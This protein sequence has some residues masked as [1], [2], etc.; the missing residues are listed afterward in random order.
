MIAKI[1]RIVVRRY[2]D[3][4]YSKLEI[5]WIDARGKRGL[6]EGEPDLRNAHMA[7]LVARGVREGV[8]VEQ[9]RS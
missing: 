4:G 2:G 6:T 9:V 8:R 3:S 7:A 1:D 5:H